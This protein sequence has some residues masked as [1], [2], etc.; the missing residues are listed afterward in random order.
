VTFP[1]IWRYRAGT[2][3]VFME[4]VLTGAAKGP[5]ISHP[6]S[7]LALHSSVMEAICTADAIMHPGVADVTQDLLDVE[8]SGT[9][10][11]CWVFIS[12]GHGGDL[13]EHG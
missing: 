2:G 1:A 6:D 13:M 9:I 10:V 7:N 5:N 3:F 11:A 8:E 12:A 4:K